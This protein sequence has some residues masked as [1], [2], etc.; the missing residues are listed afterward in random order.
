M[1][2]TVPRWRSRNRDQ[3]RKPNDR[4]GSAFRPLVT[5]RR[6]PSYRAPRSLEME[7]F[8]TLHKDLDTRYGADL[9]A[10]V[11]AHKHTTHNYRHSLAHATQN[12]STLTTKCIQQSASNKKDTT[13]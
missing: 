9:G 10:R 11:D 13:F 2:E 1:Q 4:C 8:V 12:W 5:F 3:H 7:V 6:V